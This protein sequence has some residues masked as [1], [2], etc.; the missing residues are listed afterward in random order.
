MKVVLGR[1]IK[2][3]AIMRTLFCGIASTVSASR[4]S[5]NFAHAKA[6][7]GPLTSRRS[8]STT[9]AA[10]ASVLPF[11]VV[12]GTAVIPHPAK[13]DKG[14]EDACFAGVRDD[15]ATIVGVAD[16][17]GGWAEL[18]VDPARFSRLLMFN[19]EEVMRTRKTLLPIDLVESLRDAWV[20]AR[21]ERGSS[22]ACVC[23]IG[24]EVTEAFPPARALTCANLG[25][26]GFVLIR[27]GEVV[28]LS[29]SQQHN[30]NFPYQLGSDPG[31][32]TPDQADQYMINMR[33]GDVLVVGT[34]GLFDNVYN[35]EIV[36]L[37]KEA[38]QVGSVSPDK[39]AEAIASFASFKADQ[40]SSR[41]PFADAARAAGLRFE[42]GK[43]DDIT[44]VVSTALAK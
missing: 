41:T 33:A 40:P 16:G 9:T 29:E 7:R 13:A 8:N 19:A 35:E 18:G 23:A 37:V 27:D 26:S 34:D 42:G 11:D 17:V 10:A 28:A 21:A 2:S 25:D 39:L 31:S 38:S 5:A 43:M 24:D 22:T 32:D 6:I 44:V 36:S 20:K 1:A 15:G 30:F 3:T 14:G 12:S 4:L